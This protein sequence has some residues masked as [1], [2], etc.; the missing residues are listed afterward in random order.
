MKSVIL[1]GGYGTRIRP[2]TLSVPKPLVDF[3]NRPVIEHQI[4]ACKNAGFDHVIIAVTEHHNI[5]EPIKNLAEKYSI[6]IDF[7]TESTPLGTA[8]PLRLAKDLICSDDDSDEFVVFNSDIICNY[9]LKELL[10]SHRKKSAKVTIMVTTVENSSEFGVILHD[11]NGLIKSFLEKPKNATSNTINAGVYVL[12]K[13]VLDHIPLKNYSI[14]KQFFPK[15]LKYNSSYIYKLN[16]FW[17]DIGK[18]TGYLNGQNLFLS[19]VQGSEANSCKNNND[20]KDGDFSP[21][22][23]AEN[24]FETDSSYKSTETKFRHP[25]LI[26]PTGVI[27]NDCVI[28]PN[29]CIGPNVVIGDG[30]RILNS[31]L[32]KEV[33][34]ES[35]CYIADSIIGWRSLIKQWCR[36]EGLSVFGENVIVD[37]SLYIRGCIV[38]PHKTINSSVYEDGRVII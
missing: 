33:K 25:V 22:I 18:P 19:H 28:G 34:V 7:S 4:Q 13:E 14:E 21:L 10:E 9:P 6:R 2:L 31:T 38:L 16:G 24:S 5:T 15:Y 32:F 29:V 20:L 37:E 1:A 35:Y 27:G 36:I 17:S 23:S 3:C 30:C 12:S 11:E 8:G 26:H